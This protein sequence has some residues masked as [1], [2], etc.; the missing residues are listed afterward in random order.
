[1]IREMGVQGVTV[2]EIFGLDEGTMETVP[3][4]IYGLVLL[5]RYRA[6]DEEA[7]SKCP[8]NIWFA[9]QM[10]N[11]N[12][13]A[14]LAM[15]NIL[16]NTK[17]VD[18]GE[19]LQQFKEFT[20]DFTPYLKGQE[21]AHFEFVKTIHNSFAKKMDMLQADV[22]LKNNYEKDA[23]KGRRGAGKEDTP[24]DDEEAHHFIA[25]LPI[26]GEV[27]KLDGM[28]KVPT[29]VGTYE[30]EVDWLDVAQP[31]LSEIMQSGGDNDYALFG[32]VQNPLV[33]LRDSLCS[34]VVTL[35]RV[36]SRLTKIDEKWTEKVE[37]MGIDAPLRSPGILS[38]FGVTEDQFAAT[39]IPENV[40]ALIEGEG[41]DDLFA[42]RLQLCIKNAD[43]QGRILGEMASETEENEKADARR[44]DYGPVLQT[45]LRM[46]AENGY[47]EEN[48]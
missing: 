31:R 11:Q 35:D 43:L 8:K 6:L 39:K 21:V 12:S 32:L 46:L 44:F 25:F 5:F 42:R 1:M 28:D 38:G 24:P 37:D 34:N 14:T 19:N 36:E 20:S 45:W 40:E 15:L 22:Q 33:G 17:N 7:E 27:W 41:M 23:K 48:L 10:P 9:N 2:R 47:L 30:E 29:L 16:M 13:C 26:D 4:P 18:I 3:K